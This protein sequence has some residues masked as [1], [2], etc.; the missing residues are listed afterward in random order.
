MSDNS[1]YPAGHQHGGRVRAV[2]HE[3][4]IAARH[5]L[6]LSTGI[7]PQGWPVP[8]IPVEVWQRLPEDEDGLYMA[9]VASF[10]TTAV[11]PVAGTQAAIQLLPRL[12]PACR[13]GVVS[14]TYAE[15]VH[16]W[17]AAGHK[18][19]EIALADVETALDE[20]D[21]LV[22]VNPNNPTG[23]LMAPER[24]FDWNK[25]LAARDGWLV[26][27][28]AFIEA[29]PA[30]SIAGAVPRAGLI[31]LRSL[32]KFWGLA[33]LRMGFVLAEQSLL[34]ALRVELGPWHVSHPARWIAQRALVDLPWR[35]ATVQR[36][37]R[38][39]ARLT[40]L[41]DKH[42]WHTPT[43]CALFRWVPTVHAASLYDALAKQA[44]LV[45]GFG[46]GVRFGLP[47]SEAAWIKL[48]KALEQAGSLS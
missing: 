12:R 16:A 7:N 32:G 29:T 13:V 20:V 27:D 5:W 19:R 2:A 33:G 37:Q 38:D 40:A 15:H 11:L 24:L 25:R 9:M 42:G 10:G 21:V 41:L 30:S 22:V 17:L 4:R 34:D 1:P 39:S 31:V 28:E 8:A 45:R 43:G 6:D 26:V 18:V 47:G 14:P 46:E 23:D 44:V 3:Y 35:E 36:L 48:D